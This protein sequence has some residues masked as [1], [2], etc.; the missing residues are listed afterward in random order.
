MRPLCAVG[1]PLAIAIAG[2]GGSSSESPWPIE[3]LD[4]DPG[5]QGEAPPKGDATDVGAP[6]DWEED[7]D[8]GVVD[9]E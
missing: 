8:G 6:D 2:C 5:P 1:L 7:T 3:P 4:A 9:E